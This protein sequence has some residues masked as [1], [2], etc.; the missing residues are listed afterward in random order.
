M[1]NLKANVTNM[2]KV[3]HQGICNTVVLGHAVKDNINGD[4][5][6]AYDDLVGAVGD[7][8]DFNTRLILTLAEL[9]PSKLSTALEIL[10]DEMESLV[11]KW[12][13]KAKAL[14]NLIKKNEEKICQ[15]MNN[16][17]H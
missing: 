17:H 7:I 5:L 15:C 16:N 10:N 8:E 14:T 11:D 4:I 2:T 3:I 13:K 12:N 1:S 9:R 6:N